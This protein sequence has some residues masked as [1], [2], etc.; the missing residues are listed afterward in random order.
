MMNFPDYSLQILPGPV[1]FYMQLLGN[2]GLM[3]PNTNRIISSMVGS[4]QPDPLVPA[5]G[6]MT[7]NKARETLP[8]HPIVFG[9]RAVD[10]LGSLIIGLK[11]TG[12]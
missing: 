11:S 10:G 9:I 6:R 8:K 4:G 5:S 1:R 2:S 3:A 12:L 7:E